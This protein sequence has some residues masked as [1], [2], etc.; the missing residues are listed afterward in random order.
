[1]NPL[2]RLAALDQSVWLDFIRRRMLEDGGLARL[3]DQD[4]LA[5]V[6]SNPAIFTEAI[7][8]HDDY[9]QAIGE[10]TRQGLAPPDLYET[11]AIADVQRAADILRPVYE[12]S[13]GRDGYVSLEVSPHLAFDTAATIAEAQRLWQRLDR[14]NAMIKIPATL[15]GL[16]AVT[17]TLA[18]GL[19]INVTLI[20]GVT[21]YK[22]VVDAFL[23]GLEARRDAGRPLAGIS[24]VASFFV[25][26]I[27]TLADKWLDAR[28]TGATAGA[29]RALRGLTATACG[30]LA[31]RQF[32]LWTSDARW[33]RLAARGARPQRLLW[34]ST[35]TK[36]AAYS[37][38][39]YV[40]S[41][42]APQT[43]TTLPPATLEA[44]RDHGR[45]ERRID[46]G[47]PEAV[48]RGLAALGIDLEE[49][50]TELEAD[51]VR[52]FVEPFDELLASLEA[53]QRAA[54]GASSGPGRSAGG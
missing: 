34:A 47:D 27:D 32:R 8:K 19:N 1:M 10:L 43:V 7:V 15:P 53:A 44:Y 14:P 28:A 42:I 50:A 18:A 54:L 41:L 38:V 3:R 31:Y 20:F 51:G 33:Q 37:D 23:A 16:P 13:G 21:R 25:S 40:E 45:P 39:K 22:A 11:L 6:T 46:D 12:R 30:Q 26:R 49:L 29:A 48:V 24:S 9:G 2:Q 36:D 35:G 52:K 5:G 17:A 4:A